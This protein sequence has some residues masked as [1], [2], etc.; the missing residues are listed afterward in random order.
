[1]HYS[2]M[3][4]FSAS[5]KEKNHLSAS[6]RF[7]FGKYIR[8]ITKK[9]F[10]V[11]DLMTDFPMQD[12]NSTSKQFFIRTFFYFFF[13]FNIVC[14]LLAHHLSKKIETLKNYSDG[15][16]LILAQSRPFFTC[17]YLAL[18]FGV[19][20]WKSTQLKKLAACKKEWWILVKYRAL[21]KYA[22]FLGVNKRKKIN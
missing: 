11:T 17:T 5:T 8:I 19:N 14:Q 6:E 16:I 3:A 4:V 18:V 1:M 15:L 7:Q 12:S 9:L 13:G 2:Y 21:L 10:Q 20:K 22:S